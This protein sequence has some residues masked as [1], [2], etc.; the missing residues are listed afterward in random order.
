MCLWHESLVNSLLSYS[1]DMQRPQHS[2]FSDL[3]AAVL[4]VTLRYVRDIEQHILGV[5]S[6]AC[7]RRYE[8]YLAAR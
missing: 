8:M 5:K 2:L 1:E 3:S 6:V 7:W 4:R